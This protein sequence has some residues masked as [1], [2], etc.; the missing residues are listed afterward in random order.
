MLE[1]RIKVCSSSRWRALW[2]ALGC[3][4]IV[5]AIG[6]A[7]QDASAAVVGPPLLQQLRAG[8]CVLVMRH[9]QAPNTPP[10]AREAELDNVHHERQLNQAGQAS[11]RELGAALRSLHVPIGPIYSSPTFRALQTIRLIHLGTP[12]IVPELAEGKQGM[13]SI[14][15]RLQNS[16]LRRAVDQS[17]PAGSNT[18]IVT[19]TPNIV[20]AF[21]HSVADIKAGEMIVFKPESGGQPA[22]IIGRITI[23]QWQQL[24]GQQ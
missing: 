9:A 23:D 3:A 7:L 21:G 5:S 10:T 16:W 24:A 13:A 4:L 17:P 12:R 2:R 22:S 19:H 14:G 11:A 20:G 8:G 18:L 15:E 6:A 1:E